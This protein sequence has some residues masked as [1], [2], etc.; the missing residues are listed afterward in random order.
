MTIKTQIYNFIN[1]LRPRVSTV[2]YQDYFG[3]GDK[4]SMMWLGVGQNRTP[5]II[6]IPT[7]T[8]QNNPNIHTLAM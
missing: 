7:T 5:S 3:G 8:S 1:L 6:V 4:N 2:A